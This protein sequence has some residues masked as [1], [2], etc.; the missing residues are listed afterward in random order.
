MGETFFSE[1]SNLDK[2]GQGT[3]TTKELSQFIE[4]SIDQMQTRLDPKRCFAYR[5]SV[6][7]VYKPVEKW[8]IN[9]IPEMVYCGDCNSSD[10]MITSVIPKKDGNSKAVDINEIQIKEVA[11][12]YDVAHEQLSDDNVCTVINLCSCYRCA[13]TYESLGPTDARNVYDDIKTPI[14][15]C[16]FKNSSCVNTTVEICESLKH[17]ID[18]M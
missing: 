17:F 15:K 10:L 2:R 16:S 1:L 12:E 6:S 13:K 4:S 14:G 11:N 5:T 18:E 8:S 9:S 3:V 7:T